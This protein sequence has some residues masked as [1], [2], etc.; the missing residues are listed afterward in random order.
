MGWCVRSVSASVDEQAL[1]LGEAVTSGLSLSIDLFESGD[2]GDS[3]RDFDEEKEIVLPDLRPVTTIPPDFGIFPAA[4]HFEQPRVLQPDMT[5]HTRAPRLNW[6]TNPHRARMHLLALSVYV[7]GR[8]TAAAAADVVAILRNPAFGSQALTESAAEYLLQ[9]R[10][11]LR[12]FLEHCIQRT[13]LGGLIML[14]D[15]CLRV[16]E[17]NMSLWTF[18]TKTELS[19]RRSRYL[20]YR[21]RRGCRT[22][23]RAPS[24]RP[25]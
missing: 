6:R 15:E 24:P 1:P 20:T 13:R 4:Q 3:E 8:L 21:S 18:K 11:D 19:R 14:V 23:C 2:E 22:C 17:Q 5:V 10:H 25:T 9:R 12:S 16:G 7:R